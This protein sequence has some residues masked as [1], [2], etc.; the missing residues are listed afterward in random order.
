MLVI[1]GAVAGPQFQRCCR[2]CLGAGPWKA[3]V[4]TRFDLQAYVS[5]IQ[6]HSVEVHCWE[7]P[8][9]LCVNMYSSVAADL[10]ERRLSFTFQ[11][12]SPEAGQ[13]WQS[14]RRSCHV[15]S[16]RWEKN[17][18]SRG[19]G[20]SLYE[21]ENKALGYP[22]IASILPCLINLLVSGKTSGWHSTQTG[23]KL[24]SSP[25][26][27]A[28]Q[29]LETWDPCAQRRAMFFT[30]QDLRTPR[31]SYNLKYFARQLG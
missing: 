24:G 5:G 2:T 13:G 11:V 12:Q 25:L 30:V 4:T 15:F 3:E 10:E 18:S 28:S 14:H 27:L 9:S 31:V 29:M 7:P 8:A 26:A 19:F 20:T 17:E 22:S 6:G 1:H 21:N 16:F 23:L